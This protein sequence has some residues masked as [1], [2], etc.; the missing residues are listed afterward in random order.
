MKLE[1]IFAACVTPWVAGKKQHGDRVD[2]T[3]L[4]RHLEMLLAAGIHGLCVAGSTGEFP[5]LDRGE[6]ERLVRA[7]VEI[8]GNRVPVLAGVGHA[9]LEGSLERTRQA[10]QAG[11]HAALAPPPFYFSYG[12]GEILAFYER[13][14]EEA[15][16][17]LLLYN[18]PPFASPIEPATAAQLLEQERF[19]GIKDSGEGLETLQ[20][21]AKARQGRP[22]SL[23]CGFDR[24]L[25]RAL[26]MGADGA[27]SGL[28][29]CAPE[30]LMAIY[31]AAR[32]GDVAGL[33]RAQGQLAEL[34]V[35]LEEFPAPVGIRLALEARGVPVGHHA[36][37]LSQE[38][39]AA[40][41]KFALWFEQW[42]AQTEAA[43]ASRT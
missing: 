6:Y 35:R 13:L 8:A 2:E 31:G 4:W 34:I 22:F 39:E 37:P 5:R 43:R 3:A 21:L 42:L 20:T 12:Q 15:E 41:R 33:E 26:E 38:M 28:A 11:A 25:K 10:A 14:A 36:V 16:L 7:T 24:M 17:P 32:A 27:I 29:A 9:S 23:L 18:I 19:V 40:A 30:A 1:G